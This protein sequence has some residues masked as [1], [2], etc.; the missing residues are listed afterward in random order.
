MRI[1]ISL[2][3][4]VWLALA[5]GCP[6]GLPAAIIGTNPPA[7]ALTAERVALLPVADREAWTR[8]LQQSERQ[9]QADQQSFFAELKQRGL[10]E[11]L[12]PPRGDSGNRLPLKKPAAW[13]GQPEARR[14]ADIVLSFQTPAG[15]WSKNLDMTQRLRA[16]GEE[17]AG[18]N[19][20]MHMD[21]LDNE[22]PRDIHWSYVG[23]LDNDATTTQLRYLAKV[24]SATDAGQD[25]TYRKAFLH[26]LDYLFAAQYPN[27]GWPQVWPL[28]GSY[29]D[30]VTF[31]D[32]AMINVLELLKDVA[33][34][35]TDFRWVPQETRAAA[36]ASLKRG[37]A[38]TLQAQIFAG[39]RRTVWCQQHDAL[40]LQPTSAR[41]YEMP[42]QCGSESADVM[43]FLMRLPKPD[44][45]TVAAIHAAAAWFE[46]TG[47]HDVAYQPVG[48]DDR[49]LVH[50]PGA[51]PLWARYYALGT[52]RPIFGDRDQTIHDNVME[53]SKERRKGYSWFGDKPG[54]A[55]QEY[56]RWKDSHKFTVTVQ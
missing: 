23:T 53:I 31:N 18:N 15:G 51:G 49:Q 47:L 17:F 13:Y 44:P 12:L 1:C 5:F 48:N 9:R 30:A 54:R 29:H 45:K 43:I 25:P 35:A 33:E 10:K 56:S 16:P 7:L 3:L 11:S 26:G 50:V 46:K 22:R 27:G 32:G 55:L 6:M 14:I 39:G 42:S 8:Y 24:I 40:T 2:H 34:G 38:C 21:P 52:D 41:N 28:Q 19:T 4:L 20:P 36:A 37:I